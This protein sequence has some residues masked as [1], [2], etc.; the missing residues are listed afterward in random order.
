[1]PIMVGYT[2][3][4]GEIDGGAL[5]LFAI[6]ALWQMPHSYA[7]AIYRLKDYKNAA[8]PVLPLV[9]GMRVAKQQIIGYTLLFFTAILGLYQHK[10]VGNLYLAVLFP[11]TL[12]WLIY[13]V[14]GL[15]TKNNELWAKRM[16]LF[17]ILMI[18]IFSLLIAIDPLPR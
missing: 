16:F 1:M 12:G 13:A 9:R 2:A 5:L 6:L 17:S 11:M 8:I 4:R 14:L 18:V 3:V 7:I 15:S 10:Y